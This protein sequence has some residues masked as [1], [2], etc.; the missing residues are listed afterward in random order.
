MTFSVRCWSPLRFAGGESFGAELVLE[1][2]LPVLGGSAG[3]V[4]GV[5]VPLGS[6]PRTAAK[7]PDPSVSEAAAIAERKMAADRRRGFLAAVV[8]AADMKSSP[9]TE[10]AGTIRRSGQSR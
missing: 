9:Y 3:V 2:P 10:K 5:S 6:A 8:L 1:C 4:G 7:L